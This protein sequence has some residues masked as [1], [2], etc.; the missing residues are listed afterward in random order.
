MRSSPGGIHQGNRTNLFPLRGN[1]EGESASGAPA[2]PRCSASLL[3]CDQ[4]RRP[5]GYLSQ[6]QLRHGHNTEKGQGYGPLRL[7]ASA[8]VRSSSPTPPGRLLTHPPGSAEPA[9]FGL[10]LGSDG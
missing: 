9:G 3:T 2:F 5:A 7:P 8:A 1:G 4:N 10:T 6:L